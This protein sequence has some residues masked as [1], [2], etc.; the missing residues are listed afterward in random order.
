[1]QRRVG[2]THNVEKATHTRVSQALLFANAIPTPKRSETEVS[3]R[4]AIGAIL[5]NEA[6]YLLE[7][8]AHHR[9]LGVQEFFLADNVS[10][11]G[12][13]ELLSE[14]DRQGWVH[15]IPFPDPPNGQA[16]TEAYAHIYERIGS[17]VDWIAFIDGDEFIVT[18]APDLPTY[19]SSVVRPDVGAVS[20]N[21]AI[22]GSSGLVSADARPV[23]QRFRCRAKRD[24]FKNRHYKS[25]VRAGLDADVRHPHHP[26][27]PH[28]FLLV[29]AAGNGQAVSK[30]PGI[31]NAVEWRGARINHYV[32]KSFAEFKAKQTRGP[33]NKSDPSRPD[34][35]FSEHD[36]NDEIDPVADH[37]VERMLRDKAAIELNLSLARKYH[38]LLQTAGSLNI[39]LQKAHSDTQS[40]RHQVD[41]I[42]NSTSW[43][44]SAPLRWAKKMLI[45]NAPT[46]QPAGPHG[47]STG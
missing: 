46:K 9:A 39:D 30:V 29:D 22:Y 13:S 19:I 35:F 41:A 47:D 10:I 21:W 23:L 12:T 1:M 4:I 44:V 33:V 3:V 6:P 20:L 26:G 43:R 40:L 14:L 15:R 42:Y 45:G 25:I 7:W 16:Q 8:I 37:T 18:E 34:D 2:W 17:S 5:R 11:D 31:A 36:L 38:A 24:E 28:G 27:L 32:I